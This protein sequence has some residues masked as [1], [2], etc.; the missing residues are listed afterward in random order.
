M[1]LV[2]ISFHTAVCQV[3]TYTGINPVK[4]T[5]TTA[6]IGSLMGGF[7]ESESRLTQI[8]NFAFPGTFAAC[9]KYLQ[10]RGYLKEIP[11][12]E[13]LSMMLAMGIIAFCYEHR[14][15]YLNKQ[16]QTIFRGLWGQSKK[17]SDK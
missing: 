3:M 10:F 4:N 14:E 17:P 8:N 11:H 6:F 2:I 5:F 7:L 12:V 13:K 9:Y 15:L 1:Y 16:S